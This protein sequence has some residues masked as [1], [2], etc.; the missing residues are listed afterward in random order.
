[1]YPRN[2]ILLMVGMLVTGCN[3]EIYVRNGVT[4]G[5]TFYLADRALSD[6]DPVLQSWVAYSLARSICQLEIGGTNPARNS[7]FHCE[8]SSRRI[9]VDS[10]L[11]RKAEAQGLS[12]PYLDELAGVHAAGY[13]REYVAH[14]YGRSTWQLPDDLE[15]TAFRDWRRRAMPR[16]RPQTNIIGSWNYARN[17]RPDPF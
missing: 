11:E 17:T 9:L 14:Y 7:S 4:D 15:A 16:H 13:L 3:S 1:M 6:T 10:W 8:M 12:D 2:F 5:D